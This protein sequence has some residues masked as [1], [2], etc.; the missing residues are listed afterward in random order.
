[1]RG[2][3]VAL[4]SELSHGGGTGMERQ[5]SYSL[6]FYFPIFEME[7]ILFAAPS[8]AYSLNIKTLSQCKS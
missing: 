1:M 6:N 7:V 4:H 5:E 2:K 8:C 3:C